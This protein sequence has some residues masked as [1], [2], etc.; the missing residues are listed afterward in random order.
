MKNMMKYADG[1]TLLLIDEFGT[2]TE[3]Q[4]GGAIAEAVLKQFC[5]KQAYGIITTHYQNLKHLQ[6]T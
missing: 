6:R 4:I 5:K 1:N 3:P 2:G